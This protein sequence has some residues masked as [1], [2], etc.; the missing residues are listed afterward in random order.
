MYPWEEA[1]ASWVGWVPTVSGHLSFSLIG[2]HSTAPGHTLINDD[3]PR[4]DGRVVMVKQRR[5]NDDFGIPAG[6]AEALFKDTVHHYLMIGHTEAAPRPEPDHATCAVNPIEDS[7]GCLRGSVYWFPAFQNPTNRMELNFALGDLNAEAKR[8]NGL[9]NEKERDA[10]LGAVEG[11]VRRRF[12]SLAVDKTVDGKR[13]AKGIK[14]EF[15]LYRTGEFRLWYP[16]RNRNLKTLDEVA[17]Q[18]FYFAKD[19]AH[20]HS[21]H[22]AQADQIIHLARTKPSQFLTPEETETA[23]RNETQWGLSRVFEQFHRRPGLKAQRRALGILAY[24]DAF[25]AS[26]SQVMRRPGEQDSFEFDNKVAQYD[27]KHR[28]ES[29]RALIEFKSNEM[30]NRTQLFVLV[31]TILFASVGLW[32]G[33][34]EILSDLC[35]QESAECLPLQA[36]TSAFVV[37]VIINS[38]VTFFFLCCYFVAV[39]FLSFTKDIDD[40]PIFSNTQSIFLRPLFS[41]SYV[42]S[43]LLKLGSGKIVLIAQTIIL[44]IMVISIIFLYYVL[45]HQSAIRAFVEGVSWSDVLQFFP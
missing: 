41:I 40:P 24:A 32:N 16:K 21:H 35:G 43:V 31:A 3:K 34:V 12:D 2:S 18:V 14:F 6:V 25:Q 8:V 36:R 5:R 29:T 37:S 10:G 23:W 9:F 42:I 27:N 7:R 28:R 1:F 20:A 45:S 11:W 19:I 17:R 30:S 44:S 26:L 39:L 33:F 4:P 22:D 38:P 13:V 15:A